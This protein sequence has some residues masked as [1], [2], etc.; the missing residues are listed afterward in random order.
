MGMV[1]KKLLKL[2][3]KNLPGAG[4]RVRLM[5]MCGYDIGEQVYLGEDF[6]IIDDLS[7]TQ[8]E[9]QLTIGDRVAVSPRVTFVMHTQPNDSRIVPYVNSHK[10]SITVEQDAWIGTGAVILPGVTIGEGAVVGANSVVS[11]NVPRYTVVGGVPAHYIKDVVV[12]WNC[13]ENQ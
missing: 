9:F 4:L 5:R 3:A 8:S 1:K 10:G 12:P 11:K 13:P 2:I 6:I 7:D